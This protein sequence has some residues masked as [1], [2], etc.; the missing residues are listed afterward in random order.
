M[1]KGLTKKEK[2]NDGKLGLTVLRTADAVETIVSQVRNCTKNRQLKT[3]M[4]RER[5]N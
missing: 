1:Q 4:Q 2:N 5:K 3:L